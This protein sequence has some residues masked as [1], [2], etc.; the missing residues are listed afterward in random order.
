MKENYK[1]ASHLFLDIC[2]YLLITVFLVL[3]FRF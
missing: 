2:L 3:A 1:R